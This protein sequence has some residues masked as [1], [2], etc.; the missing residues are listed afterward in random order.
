M[1]ARYTAF[2]AL[3]KL[4]RNDGYSNIVL[5]AVLKNSGLSDTDRGFAAALFYGVLER[6]I[7]LDAVIRR[8]LRSSIKL[9]QP[10]RLILQL[11]LSNAFTGKGHNV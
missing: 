3:Q 6:G 4:K 7:T 10:V 5:D 2:Q 11:G 9:S 8:Y 1:N